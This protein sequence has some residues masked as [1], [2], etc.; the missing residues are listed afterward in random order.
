MGKE[1][2]I[3]AKFLSELEAADHNIVVIPFEYDTGIAPFSAESELARWCAENYFSW[4]IGISLGASL[5]YTFASLLNESKRPERLTIINPFSS[6]EE[7]SKEKGF[8]M[9]GQWNFS[10]IDHNLSLKRIDVVASVM[11]KK[12]PMYHGVTLLNKAATDKKN[13]IFVD[14]NHQIQNDAAQKELAELL[15]DR[16]KTKKG[17]CC[18]KACYCNIY[19]QS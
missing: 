11:D 9:S 14:D 6:R 4:W 7:L 12:I 1:A 10:P 15:L 19:Q 5:A 18:G 3:L 2:G 8:S 13:L 16:I 17:D